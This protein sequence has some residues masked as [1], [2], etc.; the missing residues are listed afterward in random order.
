M[1]C[2]K[3]KSVLIGVQRKTITGIEEKYR[4]YCGFVRIAFLPRKE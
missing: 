2:P 4:C 1:I 3:C